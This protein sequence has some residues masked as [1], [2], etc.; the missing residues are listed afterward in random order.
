MKS[1][2][3]WDNL[4]ELPSKL[5]YFEFT[6]GESWMIQQHFDLL[7]RAVDKGYAENIDIHY[8]TNTT[9]YPKDPNYMETF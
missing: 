6:G 2:S 7:R 5:E 3:F 1:K 9:Q 8:N 4:D